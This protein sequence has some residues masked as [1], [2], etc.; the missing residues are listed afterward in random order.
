MCGPNDLMLRQNWGFPLREGQASIQGPVPVPAEGDLAKIRRTDI[1]HRPGLTVAAA[2][3]SGAISPPSIS[4]ET[5]RKCDLEP[6]SRD[7][8]DD[9]LQT[10]SVT[11]SYPVVIDGK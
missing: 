9:I 2:M 8:L 11:L 6:G 10:C 4:N 7:M 3:G 1:P 5:P